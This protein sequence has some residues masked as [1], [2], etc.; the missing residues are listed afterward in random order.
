MWRNR[1]FMTSSAVQLPLVAMTQSAGFGLTNKACL[2]VVAIIL[3]TCGDPRFGAI[4]PAVAES[5]ADS[6]ALRRMEYDLP[7]QPLGNALDA[8]STVSAIQIFYEASL[9]KGRNSTEVKGTF[10]SQAALQ[11]L[12][13]GSGLAARAIAPNT[14]SIVP[15]A[16]GGAGPDD[17]AARQAKRESIQYFGG[18]QASLMRA[19]CESA[20]T[21]PGNYRVAIQYWLDASGKM[22]RLR[23]IGSSGNTDRDAAIAAALQN[24]ALRP[25]GNMPQPVTI[26]IEPSAPEQLAG[27][28]PRHA[29]TRRAE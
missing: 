26:T 5:Y 6:G 10:A 29:R 21:R 17:P 12:L 4:R 2:S 24:V 3:G 13:R 20:T 7:V 23:L 25:P 11:L 28:L 22:V 1:V 14:I 19:L 15:E 27:C 9:T 8:F 16:G 18:M